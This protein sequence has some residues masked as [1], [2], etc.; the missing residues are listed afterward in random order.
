[1]TCIV[2]VVENGVVSMGGDSAGVAGWQLT[3]RKDR[4][5]FHNEGFLIGGTS[6]FRMLQLLRYAF[7][8]PLYD[9]LTKLDR[10][11]ATTFVGALRQCFKDGG[12]AQKNNEQESGGTFLV[13]YRGH[14][15][16]IADDYQVGESLNNYAAVGCGAEVALGVL[17]ATPKMRPAK[18]LE[19]ALH[20]AQAHNAGVRAPFYI[21]TLQ[22]E[23][24]A[25]S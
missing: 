23:S 9:G 25:K 24:E 10:Y 21:E 11:M 6:S 18:R 5:V 2:A 8:P 13:G 22:D 19:L 3:L 16:E 20:A 17:Y 1:M 14:L 15:F 4:K 7:M 12:Y